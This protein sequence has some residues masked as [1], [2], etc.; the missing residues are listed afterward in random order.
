MR[1]RPVLINA[2]PRMVKQP[3]EIGGITYPAG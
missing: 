3:I 1:C 2:E